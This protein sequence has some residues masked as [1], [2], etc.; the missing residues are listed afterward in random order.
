M[1]GPDRP[2]NLT[3]VDG[4]GAR[5]DPFAGWAGEEPGGDEPELTD[6]SEI[7][8][9][10]WGPAARTG[11]PSR[12]TWKDRLASVDGAMLAPVDPGTATGLQGERCSTSS[13]WRQVP[14]TGL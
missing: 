6:E 2:G 13:R 4:N 14:G 10:T 7:A 12:R 11:Q 3:R 1:R 8:P 5:I 9:P